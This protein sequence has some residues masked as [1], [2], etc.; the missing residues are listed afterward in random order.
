MKIS[1]IIVANNNAA[2]I[3]GCVASQRQ[4]GYI[5]IEHIIV[6]RL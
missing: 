2:T 3:V 6:M 5:N 1:L 4:K